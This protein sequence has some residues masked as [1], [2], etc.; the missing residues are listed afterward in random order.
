MI[1]LFC[2]EVTTK[3]SLLKIY[4]GEVPINY[5]GRTYEEGKKLLLMMVLGA[6]YTLLKYR[7]LH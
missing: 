3:L 2:P 6:I 5:K 7:F 4:I 1:F